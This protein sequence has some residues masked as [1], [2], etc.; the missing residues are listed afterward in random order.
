MDRCPWCRERVERLHPVPPEVVSRELVVE[1]GGEV[2]V[3]GLEAC[4]AC[5]AA[6]MGGTRTP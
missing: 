6:F 2:G 3:D 1:A 4:A 5:I